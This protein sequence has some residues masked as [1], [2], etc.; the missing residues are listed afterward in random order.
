[1]GRR[2]LTE[3]CL[4]RR[5]RLLREGGVAAYRAARFAPDLRETVPHERRRNRADSVPAGPCICA[6]RRALSRMQAE[7]RASGERPVP[8]G[9]RNRRDA[10]EL[11]PRN[12][13]RQWKSE[14][15]AASLPSLKFLYICSPSG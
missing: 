15:Q 7:P 13:G 9:K 1:M 4:V 8:A 12:G 14:L 6:D 5:Q 10:S 2:H 11:L 3:R